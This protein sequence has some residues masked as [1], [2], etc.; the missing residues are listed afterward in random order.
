VNGEMASLFSSENTIVALQGI[1]I[2]STVC[3]PA[4]FALIGETY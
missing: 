4:L 2:Y 1:E 3:R